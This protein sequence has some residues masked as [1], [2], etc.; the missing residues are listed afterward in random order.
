M[1]TILCVDDNL[2]LLQ[3][4]RDLLELAGYKV[5]TAHDGLSAILLS[6]TQ[7]I[8]AAVLDLEMQGMNGDETAR[9]LLQEK[10]SLP[11][12]LCSGCVEETPE[13]LKWFAASIVHK[14]DGPKYLLSAIE[15]CMHHLPHLSQVVGKMSLL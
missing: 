11:I 6:R 5:S 7:V 14:G 2:V 1:P 9:V 3:I 13:W 4:Y 12:I 10:P 15:Q 8:H